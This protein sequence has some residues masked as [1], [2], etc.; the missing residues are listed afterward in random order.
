MTGVQTCALPILDELQRLNE[1]HNTGFNFYR[2]S[3]KTHV[4]IAI[5][6]GG[7]TKSP[8]FFTTKKDYDKLQSSF[9]PYFLRIEKEEDIPQL[10]REYFMD[11]MMK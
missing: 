7:R 11:N 1:K 5:E 4:T 8:K 3:H 2:S 6:I 9:K 10:A